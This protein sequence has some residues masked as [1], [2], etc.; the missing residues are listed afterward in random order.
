MGNYAIWI[1]FNSQA[2]FPAFVSNMFQKTIFDIRIV[3][4]CRAPYM[5]ETCL[6]I[7]FRKHTFCRGESRSKETK[8]LDEPALAICEI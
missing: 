3:R 5:H 4:L 2:I 7:L 8:I 6:T 1:C